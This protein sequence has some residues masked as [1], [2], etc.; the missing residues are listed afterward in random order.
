MHIASCYL[1]FKN[2]ES[3]AQTRAASSVAAH[4]CESSSQPPALTKSAQRRLKKKARDALS[5]LPCKEEMC[6]DTVFAG[7]SQ[8][9][10]QIDS[11][12]PSTFVRGCRLS[13]PLYVER[14][15]A[16]CML[17]YARP[18]EMESDY[19][20]CTRSWFNVFGVPEDGDS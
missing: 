14:K 11:A 9:S 16:H 2:G 3:I 5:L 6:V 7:E 12:W 10:P 18:I 4:Q 13:E 8:M 19:L 1:N 17:T 15:M 20:W